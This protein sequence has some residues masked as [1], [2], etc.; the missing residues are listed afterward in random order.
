MAGLIPCPLTLFVMSFAM[1]RGVPGAGIL[2]AI[3]MMLGVALTLSS[4]AAL[5]ILLRERL[6]HFFESRP[7]LFDLISRGIEGV[8]GLIL[9]GVAVWQVAAR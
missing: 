8:A 6:V 9:A 1:L 7:F 3:T 4:V 2:F 5:S